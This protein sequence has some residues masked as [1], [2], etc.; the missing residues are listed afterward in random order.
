MPC[1]ITCIMG[2][3]KSGRIVLEIEPTVKKRLYEALESDGV[4]L[5]TWFLKRAETFLKS[6]N[7]RRK[8]GSR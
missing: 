7:N 5:K 3:G 4:T 2:R 8:K 6:R 1:N